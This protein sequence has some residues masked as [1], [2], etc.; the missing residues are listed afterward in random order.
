MLKVV[1]SLV[2]LFI[3]T[4]IFLLGN[5]APFALG[6]SISLL[7]LFPILYYISYRQKGIHLYITFLSI[8]LV[9]TI[10]INYLN[11][12]DFSR[13]YTKQA[14]A[15]IYCILILVTILSVCFPLLKPLSYA[16]D[17]DQTIVTLRRN[18]KWVIFHYSMFSFVYVLIMCLVFTTFQMLP[19]VNKNIIMMIPT[20]FICIPIFLI[21][22]IFSLK[23]IKEDNLNLI[24][25]KGETIVVEKKVIKKI[26]F[27]IMPIVTISGS[28]IEFT[29]ND[30]LL[31]IETLITI[32][33]VLMLAWKTNI[34]FASQARVAPRNKI[35]SIKSW[36][37]PKALIK[38][39]IGNFIGLTLVSFS[40]ILLLYFLK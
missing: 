23:Q 40:L 9:L 38:I 29:R 19:S 6:G 15:F 7:I 34:S 22:I 14:I 39:I 35:I 11:Y 12:C 21:A 30:W 16:H 24:F 26:Y 37:N 25:K 1:D 17:L 2:S 18:Y 13:V 5:N 27:A 4:F 10:G 33:F 3:L 36:N 32:N 31:W 28:L 8:V 20:S